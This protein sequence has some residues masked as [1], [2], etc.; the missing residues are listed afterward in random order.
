M[1]AEIKW[2]EAMK[3]VAESGTG[4]CVVLDTPD[5]GKGASPMEMLLLGMGGCTAVDVVSILQKARQPLRDC[6]VLVEAEREEEYPRT[7]KSIHLH[8]TLIGN[9]LSE[10]QVQRAIQLSQ[11]KYCAASIMMGRSGAEVSH[12]YEILPDP[13]QGGGEGPA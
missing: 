7:F 5:S 11:E 1:R 3:F 12:T 13:L 6:T 8:Y 2:L 4:H 9:G 10:P